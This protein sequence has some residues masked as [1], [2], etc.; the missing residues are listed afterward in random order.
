MVGHFSF[1][2]NTIFQTP[3]TNRVRFPERSAFLS[4]PARMILIQTPFGVAMCF[5]CWK[6]LICFQYGSL[7]LEH[8]QKVGFQ[9]LF[10][11]LS[12]HFH[13]I[14]GKHL[15]CMFDEVLIADSRQFP[16]YPY[17]FHTIRFFP[18]YF[19]KIFAILWFKTIGVW[20]KWAPTHQQRA[21][22]THGLKF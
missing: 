1:R 13:H 3:L 11:S 9:L 17:I 15:F 20:K 4:P 10:S 22:F 16:R 5:R 14:G 19:Y 21:R 2:H 7:R 18:Y 6:V 8:V 12:F